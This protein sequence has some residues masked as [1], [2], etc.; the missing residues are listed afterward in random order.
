MGRDRGGAQV[1]VGGQAWSWCVVP[2]EDLEAPLL[3]PRAQAASTVPLRVDE[4]E[5]QVRHPGGDRTQVERRP[6][7]GLDEHSTRGQAKT[8]GTRVIPRPAGSTTAS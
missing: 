5:P 6:V 8:Q 3:A 4:E 2:A 1:G 7:A